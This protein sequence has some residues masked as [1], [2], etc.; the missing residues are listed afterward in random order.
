M[1]I[2]VLDHIK[3]EKEK[4]NDINFLRSFFRF[5]VVRS[6][7]DEGLEII[8]FR[9]VFLILRWEKEEEEKNIRKKKFLHFACRNV[10]RRSLGI[11]S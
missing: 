5:I 7:H 2:I 6:D 4:K 9:S 8:S 1:L 3:L 10:D 11:C